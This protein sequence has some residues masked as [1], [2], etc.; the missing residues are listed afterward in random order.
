MVERLQ[1]FLGLT[2]SGEGG[3]FPRLAQRRFTFAF[4]TLSDA[5]EDGPKTCRRLSP[6]P[7]LALAGIRPERDQS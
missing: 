2:C 7:V 5:I 3:C 4:Q 1:P 6:E